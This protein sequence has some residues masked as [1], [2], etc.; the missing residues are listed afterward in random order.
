MMYFTLSEGK[1]KHLRLCLSTL[2]VL[3]ALLGGTLTVSA[4]TTATNLARGAKA[5][6]SSD[7]NQDFVASKANDGELTT[8][9]NSAAGDRD[10]SWLA[11]TWDQPQTFNKVIVR[12]AFNRIQ[13]FHIQVIDPQTKDWVNVYESPANINPTGDPNP[14]FTI[15]LKPTITST[16][17]RLFVDQTAEVPSIFEFEVYNVPQ[18]ILKGSVKDPSGTSITGAI[19]SVSNTQTITNDQ[20]LYQMFVDAGTH[21]VTAFKPGAFRS[22]T[23]RG[24][25]VAADAEVSLDITLTPLPPNLARNATA[26]SSSDW[27]DQYDAPKANDGDFT[28]RWNSAAGDREGSWIALQWSAPQTFNKVTIREAF[29]RIRDY[30]LQVFDKTKN[31]FVDVYRVKVPPSGGDPILTAT[32]IPPLT[33]DQLRIYFYE[34]TEVP[35]IFEIE[36]RNVPTG[37]LTGT[38]ADVSTGKPIPKASI[39]V[40]PGGP[41]ATTD[42]NGKFTVTLETDE[43]AVTATAGDY[44]PGPSQ[45]VVISPDK[46]AEVKL[47]LPA[48]GPNLAIKAKPTASSDDGTNLPENVIDG[49]VTTAWMSDPTQTKMQWIALL[50][51]TP[52]TFTVVNLLGFRGVIQKSR[53]EV[54]DDKGEWQPVPDTEFAPEFTGPNRTIFL[55]QPITTKGVRYFIFHTNADTNVPGLSEFEVYNSPII[56]QQPPT[57]MCGDANGDG[58][59]AIPD[60][61]LALQFAVGSKKPTD[62]QLAS[63]DFNGNGKVDIAEVILVLRKAVNPQ[64]SITGKGCQ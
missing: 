64:T 61:I 38:V 56:R 20:G 41:V 34:V 23:F 10:G 12:Q 43:Y 59:V 54:Q 7:W 52:T 8:R 49:D 27:S 1:G 31:D 6:S 36:V 35:S 29:D 50:W 51:D 44:F 58:K 16:G 30:A 62:T 45:N 24:I 55:P 46:P 48:K 9:W 13:V 40:D 53:I 63:L 37:I 4:Q 18:G 42:D 11:L 25:Q 14:T 19:V 47:V 22:R 33:T 5:S 26:S 3:I 15:I 28:T 17:V 57:V 32:L 21:N 39:I 2:S 60:A